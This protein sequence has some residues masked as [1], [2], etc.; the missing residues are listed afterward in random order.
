VNHTKTTFRLRAK[1]EARTRLEEVIDL[2]AL[3]RPFATAFA[4]K[5]AELHT[6]KYGQCVDT[7]TVAIQAALRVIDI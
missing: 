1:Q 5:F 4:K 3:V 2:F 7:G 6:A